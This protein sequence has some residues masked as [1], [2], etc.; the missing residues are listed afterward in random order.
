MATPNNPA[1]GPE[2]APAPAPWYAAFPEPR[3]S[4]VAT[5]PREKVLATLKDASLVSGRD[6][7]LVDLRRTDF[8]GGT[9]RGSINLPAQSFYTTLPAVYNLFKASGVKKVIF[10]CGS[11]RGRGSR[12][13][14]WLADHIANEGD[15]NMQS[16]ALAGGI[17]GWAVAGEEY[18]NWMD[19][20]DAAVWAKSGEQ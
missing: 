3:T 8:E 1:S 13:T 14:G 7:V 4:P 10:Y 19:G 17:K 18:I 15:T 16:L 6:Y 11:S 12:A 2:T 5:I 9:I 20:Y